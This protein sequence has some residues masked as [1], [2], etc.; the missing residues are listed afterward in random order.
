MS[1][2]KTK[3]TVQCREVMDQDL[4]KRAHQDEAEWVALLPLDRV[5]LAFARNAGT[6]NHTLQGSPATVNRVQNVEPQ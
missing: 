6:R 4:P 5:A 2:L 3:E 1:N